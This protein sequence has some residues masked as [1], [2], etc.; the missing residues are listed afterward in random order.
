M[1]LNNNSQL[2]PLFNA[3]VT[4]CTNTL[5]R[6]IT[7]K[8]R[9]FLKRAYSIN[10]ISGIPF[11]YYDFTN[12]INSNYFRQIIHKLK[13]IIIPKQ[14]GRPAYYQLKGLYLDEKLTE[15]YTATPIEQRMFADFEIILSM[16][17]HEPPAIHDIRIETLT[18]G[19]YDK[20]IKLGHTPNKHN[21]II[22]LHFEELTPNIDTKVNV[23]STGTIL[24]I[25]GCT[26]HP[27]PY[28]DDGFITLIS[29]LGSVRTAL[30]VEC[31]TNFQIEPVLN[32]RFKMF[33][34]N[35]DSISYNFPTNDYTVHAVFGHVRIY[36]KNMH[37]GKTVF[38]LEKQVIPNT[39]ISEEL[40]KADFRRDSELMDLKK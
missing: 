28:T 16:V 27:I 20:L 36:K 21:K 11:S 12:T 38:R 30:G 5:Q 26:Y 24:V 8:E 17:K 10:T 9:E 15:K 31:C 29:H 34:F 37:E 6:C 39:T 33:D 2:N 25:L 22:T 14:K 23:H 13:P 4:N 1:N 35:K 32:W 19:L 7:H 3:F 18:F 40:Y